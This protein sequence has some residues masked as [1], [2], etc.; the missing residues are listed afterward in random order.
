VTGAAHHVT[1]SPIALTT[2]PAEVTGT[3]VE[4]TG[5]TPHNSGPLHPRHHIPRPYVCLLARGRRPPSVVTTTT[6]E[7]ARV[8]PRV[9][10]SPPED[11]THRTK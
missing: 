10:L 6:A 5:T 4:L 1:A 11:T 3:S 7:V 8:P 9:H 2:S